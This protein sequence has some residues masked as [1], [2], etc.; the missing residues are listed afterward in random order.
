MKIAEEIP[1]FGPGSLAACWYAGQRRVHSDDQEYID[2]IVGM[3][4][5]DKRQQILDAPLPSFD[6]AIRIMWDRNI[7]FA[8]NSFI[9]EIEQG[10]LLRSPLLEK[11]VNDFSDRYLLFHGLSHDFESAHTAL[12]KQPQG[13]MERIKSMVK[14]PNINPDHSKSAKRYVATVERMLPH[15]IPEFELQYGLLI[16]NIGDTHF[17]SPYSKKEKPAIDNYMAKFER[18]AINLRQTRASQNPPERKFVDYHQALTAMV[19][20]AHGI[21]QGFLRLEYGS[22]NAEIDGLK[23]TRSLAKGVVIAINRAVRE[24]MQGTY[25]VRN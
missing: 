11:V 10:R 1:R 5:A 6:E 13:I 18:A 17:D 7:E 16:K 14:R 23:S 21:G 20:A 4:G 3:I 24:H 15:L 2:E 8:A 12:I 19:D 9:P 25:A 22:N